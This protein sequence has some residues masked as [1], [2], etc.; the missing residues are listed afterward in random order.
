MKLTLGQ[1]QIIENRLRK[2]DKIFDEMVLLELTDHI[3]SI[4]EKENRP[5]DVVFPEYWNSK[6]KILLIT[7]A[8]KQIEFKANRVES[9]FWKGFLKPYSLV[10]Y[11]FTLL[12]AF[13]LTEHREVF[14][15]FFNISLI[16]LMIGV[17]AT[18]LLMK[19]MEDKPFFYTKKLFQSIS[20][21]F[22]L[23]L[24][25]INSFFKEHFFSSQPLSIL[26]IMI[27]AVYLIAIVS[28]VQA[29]RFGKNIKAIHL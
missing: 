6:D 29:H 28:F 7:H 1:I 12:L 20:L 10:V 27:V 8:K 16:T 19:F 24:Q 18:F 26:Y 9:Y 17:L 2:E 11:G 21:F 15:S 5:F 13:R 25:L 3:A 23:V 4:I 22:I 14:S